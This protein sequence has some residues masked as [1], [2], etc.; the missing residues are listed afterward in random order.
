MSEPC[1]RCGAESHGQKGNQWLCVKHFRFKQMRMSSKSAGKAQ[2]TWEQLEAMHKSME[3]PDC[4][5]S[6]GWIR[7]ESGNQTISLQHYADG[8]MALVCLRCNVQHGRMPGDSWR[9]L[10][11]GMK[12]CQKCG[13]VKSESEFSADNR[14]S[15]VKKKATA[16]KPCMDKKTAA[17]AKQNPERVK[18]IAARTRQKRRELQ[19]KH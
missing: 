19:P 13:V 6:M 18:S 7:A 12:L 11:A 8:T 5:R 9:T 17:W 3:C 14:A 10:P 4:G 2:P 1:R 15:S 16:C